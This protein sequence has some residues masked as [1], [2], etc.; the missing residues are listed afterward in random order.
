MNKHIVF[1]HSETGLQ[2]MV[3]ADFSKG[4]DIEL[5]KVY[6]KGENILALL[7]EDITTD[8]QLFCEDY[9]DSIDEE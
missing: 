2:L 8:I 4:G 1:T 6:H 7:G 3:V 9:L 5:K